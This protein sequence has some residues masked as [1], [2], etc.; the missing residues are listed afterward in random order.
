MTKSH[1]D[2]TGA[3]RQKLELDTLRLL[4]AVQKTKRRG[5]DAVGYLLVTTHEIGDSVSE[6]L[7]KYGANEGEVVVEVADLTHSQ[8]DYM[9]RQARMNRRAMVTG[10]SGGRAGRRA[11]ASARATLMESKLAEWIR[12][13]EPGVQKVEGRTRSSK[14]FKIDWDYY[15]MRRRTGIATRRLPSSAKLRRQATGA[16]D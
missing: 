11:L 12:K 16:S 1:L 8:L 4:Y 2:L 7:D 6:W 15:G 9:K 14:P 10:S 5:D 13:S 3:K